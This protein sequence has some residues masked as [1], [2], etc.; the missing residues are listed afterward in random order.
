[1]PKITHV[2]KAQQRY[3]RVPVM[4]EATGEP[5][6]VPVNRTTKRGSAVTMAVT[7]DDLDRP[8]PPYDCD[9]CRR[10]IAVNTP[11]KH[12]S[13]RSGPFGGRTLRR[14]ESCPTWQQW[15]YSDSLSAQLAQI[16]HEFSSAV[17]DA[18]SPDDVEAAQSEAAER[19]RELAEAKRESAQNIEDG[20]Q[21]PT[22]QSE[23]LAE[24]ADQL[25]DWANEIEGVSVPEFPE[26]EEED[27][28][29]CDGTGKADGGPAETDG[30]DCENCAGSGSVTPDEPTENQVD[31]WREEVRSEF[32]VVSEPPV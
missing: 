8:L 3:E 27:C 17:D 28:E 7:R 20:F 31:E 32:S 9:Y 4:D 25:D 1:M 15:D 5:K 12:I 16:E 24:Q 19:A 29:D 2:K 6:V 23:E 30:P 21:H 14:H 18:S 26:P 22:A 13:P 11:Y 10:P